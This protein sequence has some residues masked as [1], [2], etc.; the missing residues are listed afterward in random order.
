MSEPNVDGEALNQLQVEQGWLLDTI[1]DLRNIGISG[2][3]DLPQLIVCGNQSSGKSSVLEAIS[4][5]RFPVKSNICT[6]FATEVSLRRHPV[7]R[8]KVS[9]EPGASR[10]SEADREKVREFAPEAFT[11]SDQLPALI[12]QAKE[13]MGIQSE[14]GVSDDVLKIEIS[15]PDKPELTLVDLPGLYYSKSANQGAEGIS[16]AR[17]LTEQYMKSPRSIILATVSA[18]A[19]YHLQEVL[20]IAAKF[21]PTRDRTIGIITQPDR[22]EQHSEEEDTWLEIAKNEKIRLRLGWHTLRNRSFETRDTSD[23]E[24]DN[25]ER[26]FFNQGRW[27]TVARDS[28]GID[29]LRRRLSG[30][31][32]EHIRHS[33]PELI[34]DIE[35]KLLDR[36]TKF[37]KIG[38]PRS[39]LQQQK[40]FLLALSSN[41]ERI[42]NQ[43]LN[44]M[45][46][47][48]FFA[49]SDNSHSFAISDTRRLRATIRQLNEYFAEAMERYGCKIRII[50]VNED[51]LPTSTF[52]A[53]PYTQIRLPLSKHRQDVEKEIDQQARRNRGIELP[54]AANQLL[55]G[56]VFRDQ[57]QPWEQIARVHLV[58]TWEAVESFVNLVLQY[59]TDER[60]YQLL[61][62]SILAPQLQ[63]MKDGLLSK[64]DELTAY[65]KRGH[66]LPLGKSFLQR[67]HKSRADRQSKLLENVL[68]QKLP[69]KDGGYSLSHIKAAVSTLEETED[70]FA[71][72][73]II[74]QMQA[75]YETAIVTFI[76]NVTTLGIENCLLD[77]LSGILTSQTINNME[78]KQVQ[79][80][81]GEA[82]YI[83]E[84]RD[85]LIREQE[86]LQ[87]SLSVLNKC[88]IQKKFT[89]KPFTDQPGPSKSTK[90]PE[91]PVT[92]KPFQWPKSKGD[93][94]FASQDSI[95][96]T[97]HASQPP[98]SSGGRLSGGPSITD[99][100]TP[101]EAGLFGSPL[102][103]GPFGSGGST[104]AR[105]TNA[106]GPQQS[107]LFPATRSGS[108]FMPSERNPGAWVFWTPNK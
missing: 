96:A 87:N 28:V 46:T 37:A 54:G 51:T 56:S 31:L 43:A 45:Y 27:S 16:I 58:R 95:F 50:G 65:N 71:A 104:L 25:L 19:D 67:V 48:G 5:V 14:K 60:T 99:M 15:G 35:K 88:K 66:P 86:K 76:D 40:G 108:P 63:N 2:L 79:D 82:S 98:V 23:E 107:Q 21:D 80:L 29:S 1:D 101:K 70:Q 102:A 7:T 92:A 30:I 89:L 84:E 38:A 90:I 6:R 24:R 72:A 47:D 57:S 55:V 4:R 41:F 77:P 83:T 49:E 93:S 26:Q 64:L 22:V 3:V 34:Q 97:A 103:S 39:T 11:N 105:G 9:I 8:F 62:G 78:D 53:N 18:K 74:E 91:R 36:Q 17:G 32:L 61:M 94:I 20:D 69:K 33:L 73:E 13:C 10:V 81:A 100:S 85:R 59:L 75:Y 12:E 68:G 42:T 106:P 52:F 44:G